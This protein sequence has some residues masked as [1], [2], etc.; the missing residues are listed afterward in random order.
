MSPIDVACVQ[1]GPAGNTSVSQ[2]VTEVV[3]LVTSLGETDVV[4]LPE[5]WPQG[6]FAFD[7]YRAIAQPADGDIASALSEAARR[8]SVHLV[9]GSF[10]EAGP[11]GGLYN[12]SLVFGP[13][14]DRLGLYRKIHVFGYGSRES[15]LVS[16]GDRTV[17]VPTP[18][19]GVGLAI[20]YDLRFP[21]LFRAEGDAGARLF[22]VPAA[23]PAARVDHW[24]LLLRARAVEN[25]AFVVGCN[26]AGRDHGV[27]VGGYS[28]IV[29]PRGT[30]LAEANTEPTV[31]RARL[32]F[33]ALDVYR[34]DF[35]A[36]DDRRLVGA[37]AVPAR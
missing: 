34:R 22:V 20:C 6:Y 31:L 18:A 16:H 25:L 1:L 4:V 37:A 9:G 8:A 13:D 33:E 36:L 19:G 11:D 30:L 12:T 32:D 3:D 21:E 26:G 10:V 29:E 23:W 15:E 7:E 14:G 5:M 27:D 24:R 2:R 17:V 28:A 35:P